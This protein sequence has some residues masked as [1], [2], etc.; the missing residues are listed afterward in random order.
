MWRR[1]NHISGKDMGMTKTQTA[2]AKKNSIECKSGGA[3]DKID[4]LLRL[5]LPWETSA[6]A[7]RGDI[8]GYCRFHK[9]RGGLSAEQF[10]ADVNS[11]RKIDHIAVLTAVLFDDGA[12]SDVLC[13]VVHDDPCKNL[14]ADESGLFTME[15]E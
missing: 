5:H 15:I 1:E 9:L 14:L 11:L 12:G 7:Y 2:S 3:V 8:S 10:P 6:G 13:K 4:R